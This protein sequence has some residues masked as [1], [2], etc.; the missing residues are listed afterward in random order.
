[1]KSKCNQMSKVFQSR[2]KF[3]SKG[4][5]LVY[6]CELLFLSVFINIFSDEHIH[7]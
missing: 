6:S 4:S 5:A 7:I 2:G 1:M 3:L